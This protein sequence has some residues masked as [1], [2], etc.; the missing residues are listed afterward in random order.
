MRKFIFLTL[1]VV[2]IGG[3]V[4]SSC[5]ES[6]PPATTKP[7][8]KTTALQPQSG[9]TLRVIVSSTSRNLGDPGSSGSTGRSL[10]IEPLT[11]FD[12]KGN[13]TPWLAT[14]WDLDPK[15]KTMTFHLK[16]GVK[17]HDGTDFNAAAVKWNW[18]QAM[19][20][21]RI[22][23]GDDVQSIDVIEDYT[24]R[25]TFKRYSALYV[26]A[27]THT[28]P[29]FSPTAV[30]TNGKEWARTHAV[31]TG[32]F[33]QV[34][35]KPDSYLKLERF[36][37]YWGTR[38]YLDGV[39]HTVVSDATV[40]GLTMRKKDADMWDPANHLEAAQL[41]TEGFQLIQRRATVTFIAPDGGNA[42]SV[43]A[44][45]KVREAIEYAIDRDAVA[46]VRGL[47]VAYEPVHQFAT[48]GDKGYNPDVQVRKYDPKK[49]KQLLAEAGF[50]NGIK[51][52]LICANDQQTVDTCTLL[53]SYLAA[54]GIE[55]TLDPADTARRQSMVA[56]GGTGWTDA[57]AYGGTGVNAGLD[58][59]RWTIANTFTTQPKGWYSSAIKTPAFAALYDQL[60][61]VPT[62]EEAEA[63]GKKMVKQ[64]SDDAMV[65][66]IFTSPYVLSAQPYVHTNLLSVHHQIWNPE[67]DWM[68]KR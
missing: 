49:A 52:K 9:G 48:P 8:A 20:Y 34:D 35:F 14:S 3:L 36:D 43:F 11:L 67:L 42:S 56:P 17:F 25:L 37:G 62:L 54:A 6:A 65:I 30:K 51:T 59:I 19:S 40:A 63:I 28:N 27:F 15:A 21:G 60:V 38:P 50:P 1:S 32:P 39:T 33:K 22:T 12:T 23:G 5:A 24:V 68:E 31:G 46:K 4:F 18:E 29:Q 16:K 7:A 57:L 10:Y 2:L 26:F 58:Y 47:G 55:V 66:P 44:N 41:K 61:A 45:K 13:L 64:I 53:Q